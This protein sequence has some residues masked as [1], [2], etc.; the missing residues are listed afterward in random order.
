MPPTSLIAK[1]RI[2]H[3][4]QDTTFK[5]TCSNQFFF[6]ELLNGIHDVFMHTVLRIKC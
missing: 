2:I 3:G 6:V 4:L 5:A 1:I